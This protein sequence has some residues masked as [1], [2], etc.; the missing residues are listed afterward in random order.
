MLSL[1]PNSNLQS[2]LEMVHDIRAEFDAILDEIDWMDPST[3]AKAKAKGWKIRTFSDF[4][5]LNDCLG[6]SQETE[7]N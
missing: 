4:L 7:R 6:Y 3:K 1:A 2:A 5:A